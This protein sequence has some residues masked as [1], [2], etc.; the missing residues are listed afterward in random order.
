[1][2]D[3][4]KTDKYILLWTSVLVRALQDLTE[5]DDLERDKARAWLGVDGRP[6]ERLFWIAEAIGVNADSV[7]EVAKK[8]SWQYDH[9]AMEAKVYT[10]NIYSGAEE[11]TETEWKQTYNRYLKRAINK[12]LVVSGGIFTKLMHMYDTSEEDL[13]S[14]KKGIG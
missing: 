9:L 3:Q 14:M 13:D 8:I 7:I 12:R 11:Y 2:L 6:G 1:M 10:D 5:S 4:T